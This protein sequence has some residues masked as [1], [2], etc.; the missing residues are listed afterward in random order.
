MINARIAGLAYE[1]V[2]E[3]PEGGRRLNLRARNGRLYT[4]DSYAELADHLDDILT[5]QDAEID[6]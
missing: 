5:D 1:S 6:F 4:Y 3:T 2:T